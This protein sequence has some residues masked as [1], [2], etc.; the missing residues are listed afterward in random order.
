MDQEL[1]ALRRELSEREFGPGRRYSAE[2]RARLCS[3]IS[4][5]RRRGESLSSIASELSL[6][7]R[8]VVRLSRSSLRVPRFLPVSMVAESAGQAVRVIGPAGFFVDGLTLE[9]AASLLRMLR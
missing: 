6:P 2:L 3:W 1:R 5:R 8:T 7:E 4:E 9:Q